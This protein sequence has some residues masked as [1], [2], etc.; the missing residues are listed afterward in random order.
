MKTGTIIVSV[1]GGK[2]ST[3]TLLLALEV[4]CINTSKDELW[5]ISERA[6]QHIERVAA[7]EKKAA[8]A[9]R[10]GQATFFHA[11]DPSAMRDIYDF[12]AWSKTVRGG[13]QFDLLKAMGAAP[14]CVSS[15]GLCE[16]EN[17]G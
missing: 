17:D 12:V 5:N 7:W 13:Q 15:Y 14:G 6:P 16:T 9:R 10:C 3:A 8:A 1:S 11:P 2:D 4:P